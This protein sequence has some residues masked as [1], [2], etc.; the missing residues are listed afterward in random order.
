MIHG[1]ELAEGIPVY[2]VIE[3]LRTQHKGSHHFVFV[4]V[5]RP[6]VHDPF[7]DEIHRAVG[8][9]FGVHAEVALV[10]QEVQH[11]IGDAANAKLETRAI[12]HKIGHVSANLAVQVAH[13]LLRQFM[14][15]RVEFHGAMKA[16]DMQEVFAVDARHAGIDQ[17]DHIFRATGGSQCRHAVDAKAAEAV[18]VGRRHLH[19]DHVDG[20]LAAGEQCGNLTEENR[21]VVR[22]AFV[23]GRTGV[24]AGEE[25]IVPEMLLFVRSHVRRWA[26]NQNVDDFH[27][28]QLR[29]PGRQ[30]LEQQGRSRA[31]GTDINRIA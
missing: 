10:A 23:D 26:K 9:H 5:L 7:V 25:C 1:T 16:R 13:R 21:R 27:M 6:A 3:L 20:L 30:R 2:E 31:T 8:E 24:A 12:R 4:V 28:I 14:Q 11:G 18:T 17:A 15:R 29:S 22:A 19:Q